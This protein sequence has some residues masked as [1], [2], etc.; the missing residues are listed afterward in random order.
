MADTLRSIAVLIAAAIAYYVKNVS[1]SMADAC[2]SIIVSIIIAITLGPLLMGLF[3]SARELSI[4]RKERETEQKEK[5]TDSQIVFLEEF[6]NL[7]QQI[8]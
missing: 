2:A 6:Q 7:P 4:L 1:P 5:R 3:E 8:Q